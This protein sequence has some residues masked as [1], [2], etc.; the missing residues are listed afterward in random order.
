MDLNTRQFQAQPY[1]TV[2]PVG[3]GAEQGL[4]GIAFHPNFI[5]NGYFYVHYTQPAVAG[6]SAGTVVIARYRATNGNPLATTADPASASI[7]LTIPQPGP[8]HNGGWLDFGP[9]GNLY[10]SLGDG[11]GFLD[12]NTSD[13]VNP[14]GH[15]PV[16]GN[17]QDITNNLLGKILCIDVDGFDNIPGNQDDDGFGADPLRNYRIPLDNPYVGIPGDD[18]IWAYGLRNPWRCSFDRQTGDLWIGDVGEIQREE[19]NFMPFGTSAVNFGW[20]CKE[21]T[22]CTSPTACDCQFGFD[23]LPLYEY[24]HTDFRCAVTGGYVYRGCEIPSFRGHY[25]FADL[26]GRNFYSFVRS[27]Q[28]QVTSFVDRSEQF[29]PAPPYEIYTVVTFGEDNRGEIYFSDLD[30]NIYRVVDAGGMTDCNGNQRE[31][32]CDI[33]AGFSTDLNGNSRPDECD[34]PFCIPDFDDSGG[35]DGSDVEAFF[36]VWESGS[37]RGDTNG[38]GSTDG[39]DVETFFLLW[40]AGQC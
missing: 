40:E 25:L 4:L 14:P 29:R 7:V 18:E 11:G 22:L 1:L 21:G 19:I 34:P 32:S 13:T 28:G 39:S 6:I 8:T 15:T 5:Q 36:R 17:A 2:G 30:A 35:I 20:R 26:C 23:T 24:P 33:A 9:D 38:D 12:Q 10:I 31:D 16:I 27:A 3:N 37:T